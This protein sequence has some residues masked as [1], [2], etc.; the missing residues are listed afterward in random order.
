MNSKKTNSWSRYLITGL[1]LVTP[2]TLTVVIFWWII[3]KMD[4]FVA[5]LVNHGLKIL[6]IAAPTWSV[7]IFSALVTLIIITFIGRLAGTYL[8]QKVIVLAE[9][10]MSSIPFAGKILRT[11]KQVVDAFTSNNTDKF[12]KVIKIEYP[13]KDIWVIG[14]VTMEIT[15]E[16][17]QQWVH[18]FVPTTPNPTSGFL[19]IVKPEELIHWDVPI[20]EALRF[21]ISWWNDYSWTGY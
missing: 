21:V 20:E 2:L 7:T 11:I 17:G 18:V 10:I 12:R 8:V 5:P 13:R 1:L 9:Y 15:D 6:E 4:F 19:V 14:F 16:Q 3:E